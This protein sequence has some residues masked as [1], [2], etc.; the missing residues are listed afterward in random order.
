M[1][2]SDNTFPPDIRVKKEAKALTKA[3]HKV[4]LVCRKG[5]N[6]VKS[7]IVEGVRVY[8]L[9]FPLQYIPKIGNLLYFSI[10]RYLLILF[11]IFI[12]E[13]YKIDV[14]HVHD[15][16]FALATCIPG[17]ILR[18]PVIFDMHEDYVDMVRYGI[19]RQT[20]LNALLLKLLE[21]EEK[22]CLR[23]ST[24]IIVVTEEERERLAKLGIPEEKIE[25]IEN[26]EDPDELYDFSI[27]DFKNIFQNKF[28]ISYVGGFSRHRGLEI[29][30]KAVPLILNEIPNAY[31]L[32]VGDGIM[33]DYL[34]RMVKD[35]G[36]EDKV[37]FTGWVNFRDAMGYIKTS[38][39]CAIPY[40]KTR[41]TDKSFPHK[42]SQ[43]MY[44]GKPILVSNVR[45]LKRIIKET[46]CGIIFKAGD[47]KDL[48]RK[49]VEAKKQ[50]I[51]KRLG[52]N[53]RIAFEKKYNWR[54]TSKKLIKLYN[55]LLLKGS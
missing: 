31:L 3:G 41:Q 48:A 43:C 21:I 35:L 2:L 12:V 46:E 45:S 51:L 30:V 55:T 13:K 34:I 9:D 1:V 38:D 28:L 26:T 25:V 14:L 49:I 52:E 15:L 40:H 10:Y 22:L 17:K 8:R 54:N 32:L 4:F 5:K 47:H 33:K 11:V 44:F 37:T 16:P 6:Q 36:I 24:K 39:I 19:S 18:K 27:P 20:K 53:A 42:L 7:E 29:L 50:D 23:F